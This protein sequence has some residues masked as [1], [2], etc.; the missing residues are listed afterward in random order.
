MVMSQT[1]LVQLPSPPLLAL[2]Q[3]L[4]STQT[5]LPK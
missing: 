1:A 5:L 2:S 4:G 3:T